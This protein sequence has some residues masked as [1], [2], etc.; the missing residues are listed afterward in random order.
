MNSQELITE[1]QIEKLIQKFSK[2]LTDY[3]EE[4]KEEILQAAYWAQSLHAGQKRAS[5]EPYIIHPINVAHILIGLQ[6]DATAITAALLHDVLEDTATTRQEIYDRFGRDVE[7][8]VNGV[9]KINIV[10]VKNKT[11]QERETI[12]KMI[13]A[14]DKDI[15][16]IL[17]KLADKR[18]NM[19]TLQYMRQDKQKRIA[20]ECL[21]IYAPLAGKLGIYTIKT[22]LE[23]LSLKFLK[24][25]V[26]NEI[27][28]FLSEKKGQRAE[29]LKAIEKQ[30]IENLPAGRNI[31]SDKNQSKTLLFHLS[32]DED[33]GKGTG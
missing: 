3:T 8:L 11:V 16:V 18:H 24:P 10:N 20:R 33:K 19:N 32:E 26:Y 13:L 28:T 14:M 30:I 21:D 1:D 2:T 9:T 31:N 17:I 25:D 15:R 12:R 4:E 5:G 22:E 27:K 6:L 29:F 7:H 23:D